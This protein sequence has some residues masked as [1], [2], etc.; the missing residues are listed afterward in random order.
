MSLRTYKA[1]HRYQSQ[2]CSPESGRDGAGGALS[3]QRE[4]KGGVIL[5][6]SVLSS[7][8]AGWCQD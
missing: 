4:K 3:D 6:G 8:L 2:D 1:V 7:W 5:L